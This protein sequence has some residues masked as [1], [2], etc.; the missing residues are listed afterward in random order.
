MCLLTVIALIF[1]G[2][3]LDPLWNLNPDAHRA[4]QRIGGWAILLMAIVGTAC[5][6]SAIGLATR[7]PWGRQLAVVVLSLN[8]VGDAVG[9]V[10]RH[11]PRTL[12]GLPIGA[13]LILYLLSRRVVR[14]FETSQR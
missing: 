6:L 11:D 2:G 7:A 13:A 4:F 8:L 12:I 10:V 1:P 14:Y 3:L 5:L 9:A